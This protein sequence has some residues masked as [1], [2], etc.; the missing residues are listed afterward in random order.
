MEFIKLSLCAIGAYL[1]GSINFGIII[2]KVLTGLDIRQYG[3]G[4]AGATNAY[5]VLGAWKTVLVILGDAIKG[6]AAVFFGWWLFGDYGRISA[7]VFVVIGHCYPIYYGFKGGKGVLTTIAMIAVFDWRIALILITIFIIAVAITR[8]V[9]LG[10]VIC[11]ACMP[12]CMYFFFP[13][14]L[15]FTLC[16]MFLSALMIVLHRGNIKRLRNGTE[17]KFTFRQPPPEKIEDRE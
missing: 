4:N 11:S 2:T 17:R 5:R 1:L 7:F 10:S 13:G 16:A 8:Y 14:K 6:V 15:V 12:V 3:S 9:S